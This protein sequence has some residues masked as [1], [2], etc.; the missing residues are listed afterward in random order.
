MASIPVQKEICNFS[1]EDN[2]RM[3]LIFELNNSL[4]YADFCCYHPS[5]HLAAA[6]T[7]GG[8][9]KIAFDKKNTNY[10]T[11]VENLGYTFLPLPAEVFGR[12]SNELTGLIYSASL[13]FAQTN[14]FNSPIFLHKNFQRYVKPRTPISISFVNY[15]TSLISNKI[16]QQT[17]TNAIFR[18]H[19][20]KISIPDIH[21]SVS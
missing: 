16:Q 8:T 11:K 13:E 12:F 7:R 4:V 15:W 17:A 6:Q 21:L 3:D 19:A 18:C 9:N 1:Q 14:Y 20:L 5:A 2:S 10:K